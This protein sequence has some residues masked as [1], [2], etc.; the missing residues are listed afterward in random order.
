VDVE[1]AHEF[2]D[3]LARRAV[4][5]TEVQRD[6]G[7]QIFPK[8]ILRAVGVVMQLRPHAQKKFVGGLQLL[9]FGLADEFAI[10]QL[11][12]RAGAVF[13]KRHPQQ[14]LEIAQTAAAVLDIWLLHTGGIAVL[15]AA[16]GLILKPRGNVFFFVAEDAFANH[17]FFEIWR[18]AFH[19]RR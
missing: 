18:T 13:E 10:L 1:V 15:A 2:L 12:Q 7:L 6:G 11:A 5:V 4:F 17:R 14:I 19:R 16:R 3:A 9:A 8:H